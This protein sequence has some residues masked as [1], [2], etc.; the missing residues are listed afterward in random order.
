MNDDIR[1]SDSPIPYDPAAR[2][3]GVL[4]G[5]DG[6]DQAVLALHYAARAAQRLEARLS[7]VTAYTV[8]PMVYANIASMPAETEGDARKAAAHELLE[9]ARVH[10]RGYPGELSMAIEE[11]DA[12]G[13]LVRLSVDAQL[14]VVGARGRG[15]FLGRLLGSVSSALPA[16]AHCPT[17]VV[18]R[19]YKIGVGDG[20]ERFAPVEDDAPVVVGADRSPRS[21]VAV[22]LAAEAAQSRNAPLHLVM[23]MPPPDNWGGG[24]GMSVPDPGMIEKHRQELAEELTR[25]AGTLREQYPYLTVTSEVELADPA[26]QLVDHSSRAQLVVVGTRGHG[27][28]ASVL[29]GSV[30]RSV[31]HQASGPVLVVPELD[32]SRIEADPRRPR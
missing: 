30:S 4:V 27:R 14:A 1:T 11:G 23:V 24:Y 8:P 28:V 32:P 9:E 25:Y 26:T 12:A 15:G 2:D 10:L 13:V 19:H 16:H 6:S 5:F 18:P 21:H 20:A 7:V 3:L 17:V 31:L 29:L 22:L